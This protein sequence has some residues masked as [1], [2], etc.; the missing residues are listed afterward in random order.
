MMDNNNQGAS[1]SCEDDEVPR[2]QP[3]KRLEFA[4]NQIADVA[5]PLHLETLKKQLDAI[6]YF[7]AQ[8]K[9][10]NVVSEQ[11]NASNTFRLL[12]A[13][14]HELE[15]LNSLIRPE[16]SEIFLEKIRTP[17]REAVDALA[18]FSDFHPGVMQPLFHMQSDSEPECADI[19]PLR[20]GSFE[21]EPELTEENPVICNLTEVKLAEK[22]K[23]AQHWLTLKK[24]LTEVNE[25]IK[26]FA[27]LVFFQRESVGRIDENVSSTVTNVEVGTR[28]LARAT[29]L[30]SASIPL[31]GAVIGGLILGPAGAFVGFKLFG[32]AACAV[33]GGLLGYGV[34]KKLK[35]K[36]KATSEFE[37]KA[38]TAPPAKTSSTSLPDLTTVGDTFP[39][40][41]SCDDR[42]DS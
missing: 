30:K 16:D 20:V 7:Q 25:L 39:K 34:G 37:M 14:I 33:S 27:S 42:S 40:D 28:H 41:V 10:D 4:V 1:V 11:V 2:K 31:T 35:Q 17:T 6:E 22:S 23:I 18:A 12:K 36:Q 3:Y 26:K 9:W 24:E 32:S 5:I 38:L 19:P 8:A 15:N 21:T 29:I 13:D